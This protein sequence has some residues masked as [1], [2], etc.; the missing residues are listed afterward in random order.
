V[1][2]D[3]V[4]A[5]AMSAPAAVAPPLA[6]GP[7][8][9]VDAATE[10]APAAPAPAG[11]EGAAPPM[12]DL[13]P[14]PLPEDTADS[15]SAVDAAP[16]TADSILDALADAPTPTTPRPHGPSV[17]P[18][19]AHDFAVAAPPAPPPHASDPGAP[20][21]S[22][23]DSGSHAPAHDARPSAVP[24]PPI[25]AVPAAIPFQT[26]RLEPVEVDAALPTALRPRS[27][28]RPSLPAAPTR[29]EVDLGDEGLGPLRLRAATIAGR[30]HVSLAA[31]DEHVRATLNAHGHELR[32]DLDTGVQL[33]FGDQPSFTDR[34]APERGPADER[35]RTIPGP[36]AAAAPVRTR[37]IATQAA[38]SSVSTARTR[39][40]LRL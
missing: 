8:A 18:S 38:P 27:D 21:P 37:P 12:A 34:G 28:H 36:A 19:A 31:A 33:S 16:T 35:P 26:D 1:T 11:A 30:L 14:P 39:L 13:A 29:L 7:E 20:T 10:I 32:R 6:A 40:D 15:A 22:G 3:T 9:G 24:A 4:S 17:Q 2:A 23:T 5:L 25:P